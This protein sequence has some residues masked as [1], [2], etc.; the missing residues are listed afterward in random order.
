M[1]LA[2]L[3]N[4]LMEYLNRQKSIDPD[5]ISA[6]FD[7]TQKT[8]TFHNQE[9]IVPS[10]VSAN[11][12][13]SDEV[14]GSSSKRKSKRIEIDLA[15]QRLNMFEGDK[16]VKSFLVSTGKWGK[17]PTGDFRIWT[18]LRYTRMTGGSKELNT[19]YDLPNVPYTMFFYNGDIPKYRGFGIHGAYWHN[20]FGH[21][22]SHGCINMKIEEAKEV[23]EW[24]LS[25]KD[26]GTGTLVRIYGTA[27]NS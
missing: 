3:F 25:E 9:V 10:E 27:P 23:Y 4:P 16:K 18:K 15:N 7:A 26:D 1:L 21:P 20:N 11:E 2:I 12:P 5:Q 22:M 24:A 13:T 17:T 14:L 6:V 8:A 19:F